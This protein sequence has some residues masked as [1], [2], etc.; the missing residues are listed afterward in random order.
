[1]HPILA[2]TSRLI[3]YL[4]L[5]LP[6]GSALASL[7]VETTA[8][9]GGEAVA[10]ALPLAI[11]YAFA[12][13]ATFYLCRALPLQAEGLGGLI[14]THVAAAG[15][16]SALWIAAAM[17]WS[18]A[19]EA[20]S[21]GV[22][23]RFQAGLVTMFVVGVLLALLATT[24]HYVVIALE[25][26]RQVETRELALKVLA[27]EAEL[28]ALRAQIDP[29]FLFNSLNSISALTTTDPPG[30]RRMCVLLGDFLRRSL[31][32]G[33]MDRIPLRDEVSLIEQFLAI[34]RV[35]F[36]PRLAADVAV[37]AGADACLVPPL[38]LQ[39]LVENAVRHGIAGLVEGG[40]I[41]LAATRRDDRLIV[42]VENACDPD[43][44]SSGGAGLG[45]ANVRNRL[46]TEYGADAR[47]DAQARDARFR[48][49]LSIPAVDGPAGASHP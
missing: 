26:A 7:L 14:V 17:A 10:L 40:T 24:T 18:R 15:V 39:P 13:L 36:G 2:R 42:V 5:W 20:V 3:L 34:E 12:C 30:A 32:L 9:R 31:R 43:R 48:I 1:M 19:L 45:L 28:R 47:F 38:L 33:G 35:R 16:S 11:V 46:M 8:L 4:G 49:E 25:R 27:R 6:L 23:E 29:H 21:P 44:S 22:S 41:S 37:D